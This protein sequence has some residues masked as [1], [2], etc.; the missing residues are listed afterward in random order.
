MDSNHI[1]D[2]IIAIPI[3]LIAIRTYII[4]RKIR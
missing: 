1:T 3:I 4:E 2:I